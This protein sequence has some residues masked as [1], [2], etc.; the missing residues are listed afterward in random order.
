MEE[1]GKAVG[2]WMVV[3]DGGFVIDRGALGG[4]AATD[5]SGDFLG[6]RARD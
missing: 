3:L 6:R 4:I 2:F 5:R 1:S